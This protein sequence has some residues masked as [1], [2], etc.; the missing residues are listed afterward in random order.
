MT[1]AERDSLNVRSSISLRGVFHISNI[2][3]HPIVVFEPR[4]MMTAQMLFARAAVN[5]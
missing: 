4:V 1:I 3:L 2:D 5:N